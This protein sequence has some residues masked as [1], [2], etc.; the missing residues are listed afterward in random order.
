VETDET[1]AVTVIAVRAYNASFNQ[2]KTLVDAG[3]AAYAGQNVKTSALKLLHFGR[4]LG[5]SHDYALD[6]GHM[7][8]ICSVG[9][10]V[11][12]QYKLARGGVI[13]YELVRAAGNERLVA[14]ADIVVHNRVA[15]KLGCER[16]AHVRSVAVVMQCYARRHYVHGRGTRVSHQIVKI[17][18]QPVF[19]DCNGEFLFAKEAYAFKD[20]GFAGLIG[21]ES[22]IVHTAVIAGA[23]FAKLRASVEKSAENI[24]FGCYLCTVVPKT[25]VGQLKVECFGTVGIVCFRPVFNNCLVDDI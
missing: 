1:N 14:V 6:F 10:G 15:D 18:R 13:A 8:V 24:V 7:P 11:Y 4:L 23:K 9:I 22:D 3:A 19:A 20:F 21:M 16:V 5:H 2:F 12:F 25:V 17:L